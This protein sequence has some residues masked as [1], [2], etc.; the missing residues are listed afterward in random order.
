M[1]TLLSTNTFRTYKLIES[2]THRITNSD[3]YD[4]ISLR[5]V[6]NTRITLRKEVANVLEQ[7]RHLART[8][9]RISAAHKLPAGMP[10]D[11]STSSHSASRPHR[12]KED[13]RQRSR[14]MAQTTDRRCPLCATEFTDCS[15]LTRHMGAR[16][17]VNRRG[18][19]LSQS[20]INKQ[21]KRYEKPSTKS[22]SHSAR[23][24]D[25]PAAAAVPPVRDAEPADSLPAAS[26]VA[27]TDRP[28]ISPPA[29]AGKQMEEAETAVST[30]L[31]I[32]GDPLL[33]IN[34][35]SSPMAR[36]EPLIEM[37]PGYETISE[38]SRSP[39]PKTR[40][41]MRRQLLDLSMSTI[42]TPSLPSSVHSSPDRLSVLAA[43]S[44]R[45]TT[46][47]V[48]DAPPTSVAATSSIATTTTALSWRPVTPIL[49]RMSPSAPALVSTVTTTSTRPTAIVGSTQ[50]AAGSTQDI[51]GGSL[52]TLVDTTASV[53]RPTSVPVMDAAPAATAEVPARTAETTAGTPAASTS[54]RPTAA[55]LVASCFRLQRT[56]PAPAK[57]TARKRKDAPDDDAS[58]PAAKK[59]SRKRKGD[60][61]A[62]KT[63]PDDRPSSA[64]SHAS[65]VVL[66]ASRPVSPLGQSS[67]VHRHSPSPAVFPAAAP[68]ALPAAPPAG[69][70]PYSAL[71]F[72][73]LFLQLQRAPDDDVATIAA[74]L[75]HT[76]NWT[77]TDQE[78]VRRRL[79]D[80]RTTLMF[81]V[82]EEASTLPARRTAASLDAYLDGL[83]A[84][85]AVAKAYRRRHDDL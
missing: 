3:Y 64:S 72:S 11:Q 69:R 65:D 58:K 4:W 47:A 31:A 59:P 78:I 28:T 45:P 63:V 37:P 67:P 29:A 9:I 5:S 24:K 62:Q 25:R 73:A 49:I 84:R 55:E 10:R 30:L 76:Y 33:S 66:V 48:Q 38:A 41:E 2:R 40:R 20:E 60:G 42:H 27:T 1:R 6:A 44:S 39:S 52:P 8:K 56:D 35:T 12:D 54:K 53:G 7:T 68:A 46:P 26:I 61:K 50:A 23:S 15:S 51:T 32:T 70:R 21:K 82:I 79:D 36:F 83:D 14:S 43:T 57:K 17:G 74:R 77:P 75:A 34:L 22:S 81:A 18:E 16:H 19:P 80:I 71:P 13:D 85:V